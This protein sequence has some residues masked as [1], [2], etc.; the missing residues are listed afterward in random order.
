MAPAE[1]T[2]ESARQ[3]E[4]GK[5]SRRKRMKQGL[6]DNRESP[7]TA[8]ERHLHYGRRQF[9]ATNRHMASPL[10]SPQ[11]FFRCALENFAMCQ[12]V[13]QHVPPVNTGGQNCRVRL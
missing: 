13:G 12:S 5:K 11:I 7:K 10:R 1:K 8:V 2:G 4:K 9:T 6:E 3:E